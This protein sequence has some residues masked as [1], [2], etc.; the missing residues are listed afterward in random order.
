MKECGN[1]AFDY[2]KVALHILGED[3]RGHISVAE[4]LVSMVV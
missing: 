1:I 3:V 2:R 4:L